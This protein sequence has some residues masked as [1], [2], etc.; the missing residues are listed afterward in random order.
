MKK[1][2]PLILA[3]IMCIGLTSCGSGSIKGDPVSYSNADKSFTIDLPTANEK[4]WIIN[5][6]S[7]SS[8]LDITDKNDTVTLRV[9]CLSKNQA[10]NIASDLESYEQYSIMNTIGD[11]LINAELHEK[12][13]AVPDFATD[14]RGYTFKILEDAKGMMIFMESEKCYYTYF[15]MCTE[16]SYSKNK[17]ALTESILTIKESLAPAGNK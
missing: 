13:I 12:D 8:V 3:I 11:I 4:S 14:S 15:A 10:K 17:K 2:L 1:L 16:S 5:D 9:E 7:A 6:K